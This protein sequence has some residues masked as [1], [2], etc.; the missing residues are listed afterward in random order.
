[1]PA[2]ET[3][4]CRAAVAACNVG[5]LRRV[6]RACMPKY[7]RSGSDVGSNDY[8]CTCAGCHDAACRAMCVH[9]HSM[10]LHHELAPSLL[11]VGAPMVAYACGRAT[12][13]EVGAAAEE[14][15]CVFHVVLWCSVSC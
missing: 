13:S 9:R 6:R 14:I 15:H 4:E 1:M 12:G 10:L 5:M 2:S 11:I 3:D 8:M 7:Q